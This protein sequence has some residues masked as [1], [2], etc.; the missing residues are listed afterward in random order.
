[1][2]ITQK[3]RNRNYKLL[4]LNAGAFIAATAF[5]AHAQTAG[6]GVIGEAATSSDK[7]LKDLSGDAAAGSFD[8]NKVV[9]GLI[10]FMLITFVAIAVWFAT[11]DGM[12][13]QQT[14]KDN[15]FKILGA[16]APVVV[17]II[18]GAGIIKWISG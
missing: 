3:L 12:G 11:A 15:L 6:G 1:M 10:G 13:G 17:S 16:A 5:P 4:L 2:L 8:A 9:W 14:W 18:I 7:Y